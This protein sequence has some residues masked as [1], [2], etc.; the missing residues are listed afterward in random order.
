MFSIKE[1]L[2]PQQI[3]GLIQRFNQEKT[4]Q[5]PKKARRLNGDIEIEEVS[6]MYDE[7]SASDSYLYN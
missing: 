3:N 4:S 6:L 2:S 7:I 5:W 1:Y